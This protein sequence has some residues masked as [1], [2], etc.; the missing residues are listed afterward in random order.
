MAQLEYT[1]EDWWWL[2]FAGDGGFLGVVVVQGYGIVDA[3]SRSHELEANPG[4][5]VQ[6]LLIPLECVPPV[7]FRN[8][9]LSKAEAVEAGGNVAN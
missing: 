7:Q 9:L 4:G 2:S 3:V 6:G 5:E 8:R 1:D